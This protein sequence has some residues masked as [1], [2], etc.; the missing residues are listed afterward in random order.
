MLGKFSV[1]EA[2]TLPW[3]WS[4]RR[5][6]FSF[7]PQQLHYGAVN[8]YYGLLN[9]LGYKKD[10]RAFFLPLEE[11]LDYAQRTREYMF[12]K[13]NQTA[14]QHQQAYE[15]YNGSVRRVS[16]WANGCVH[17]EVEHLHR[18]EAGCSLSPET[19]LQVCHPG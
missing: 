19:G 1:S 17:S 5:W 7:D 18:K 3:D 4:R 16:T 15:D 10:G 2:M 13:L 6:G 14:M 9:D 8:I 12:N 11:N